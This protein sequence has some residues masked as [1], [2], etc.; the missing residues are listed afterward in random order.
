MKLLGALQ[1]G[2]RFG[3]GVG[4]P[5]LVRAAANVLLASPDVEQE[6]PS[7]SI[8]KCCSNITHRG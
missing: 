1:G 4:R 2:G 3:S 5:V 6:E 7:A 8:F